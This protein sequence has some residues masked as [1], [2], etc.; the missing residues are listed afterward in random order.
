[1][2]HSPLA[3]A[4]T[5]RLPFSGTWYV[6]HGGDT[7][8]VNHHMAVRAQW[9]G[10]DFARVGGPGGRQLADEPA[11]SVAHCHSWNMPVL[12]PLAGVVVAAASHHPDN[13]LGEVDTA[14]P[15]GNFVQIRSAG[16]L[17]VVLAH[18]RQGSLLVEAGQRVEAGQPLG[19]CGN[20]GHSTM[21]Y[22]H[23]HV[24][25][26]AGFGDGTGQLAEFEGIDVDLSGRRFANVT[27]PLMRGLFVRPHEP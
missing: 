6:A 3:P 16:G 25:D 17:H 12:S 19:R 9:F 1:M 21:P 23:L 2:T 18:L 5:L 11:T 8:N 13:P 7:L 10:I 26:A 22:V 24:Q 27:W 20:S 14:Q 15:A 4:I